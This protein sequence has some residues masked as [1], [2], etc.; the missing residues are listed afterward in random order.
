[1]V[2]IVGDYAKTN[3]SLHST[4]ARV[5]ASSKTMPALKDADATLATGSPFLSCFEPALLLFALPLGALCVATRDAYALDTS[6][7]RSRFIL[8]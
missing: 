8:G 7:V 4:V 3:P 1:V 6:L 2:E 5:D